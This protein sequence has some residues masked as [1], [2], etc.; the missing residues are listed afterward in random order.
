LN[1][2]SRLLAVALVLFGFHTAVLAQALPEAIGKAIKSYKVPEDAIS[3]VVQDI[4]SDVPAINLNSLTP[5]N[6]A[7]SIKL[8]TT[9]VAL[10]VLGP[11]YTWPTKLYASGP[12]S[13][14]V[15]KGDLVLKGYG[16]P[17]LVV[18]EFW[19]MLGDLRAKGVHTITGDLVIDDTHFA[20]PESDPGAFDGQAFRLY[21]VVPSAALVNFKAIEFQF[22]KAQDGKSVDI[23]MDPN[24]PNVK[25]TNR[26]TIKQGKCAGYR[27]GI[28]MQ[29]PDPVIADHVI[30]SGAFPSGCRSHSLPR[31]MLQP[32]T[33]AYGTFKRLWAHW[34]GTIE[35]GVR[36]GVAPESRPLVVWRS[37]ALA[38]IIR[39]L[40]KWSNNVMTRLLLYSLAAA[41]FKPPYTKQQGID[42]LRG[43]LKENGLDDA[44]LI[45]DNGSGLSRETR[46]TAQFMNGLLRHA[47]ADPLMPEFIASMSLSGLDG[48]T[49]R[50]FRG[51]PE[52]G[53][54]HLKTGSIDNVAAIAGY[55][56]AGSGKTYSVS[57][58]INHAN[59]HQGSGIEIQNAVLRW[60]YRQ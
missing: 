18:E 58:M 40:N 39:P 3:L 32:S 8:L 56:V 22:F 24:M 28:N 31:T 12:I 51:R 42:V 25:I 23:R 17:F 15:L 60:I 55:V 26:L 10:D 47:Y 45:I 1:R 57:L 9:F 30:F 49:R 38:E 52:A 34:G 53:R 33:Y 4:D 54:M 36:K 50:R 48:T 20:V 16:D 11:T 19:K 14:G 27:Y 37:R 2:R 13:E 46:V 35:G 5:R 59:A 41:E 6:P 43:Y 29:V 44:D 21:N 7:S